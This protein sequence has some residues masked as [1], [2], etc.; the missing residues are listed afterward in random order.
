MTWFGWSLDKMETDKYL[1]H[2]D[3]DAPFPD[4]FYQHIYERMGPDEE[5]F[6][7]EQEEPLPLSPKEQEEQKRHKLLSAVK[8]CYRFLQL[9]NRVAKEIRHE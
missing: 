6:P 5:Q 7:E 9:A 2:F 3:N 8:N 1:Y 4:E